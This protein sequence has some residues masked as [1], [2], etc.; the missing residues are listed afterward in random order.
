NAIHYSSG[1]QYDALYETE[2]SDAAIALLQWGFEADVRRLLP[3]LLEFVREAIKFNQVGHKL[4]DVA[5]YYWQTRDAK[6]LESIRPQW[7]REIDKILSSRGENGLLPREHYCN[8]IPT[9][10]FS[11]N[12]NGKSWRGLRDLSGALAD[13]G[14]AGEAK[15]LQKVA[16][17][18]RAAVFRA[19]EQ[20]VYT[21]TSPP[22]VP[23]ALFGEEQ[24]YDP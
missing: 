1:N 5:R 16:A 12:S 15:R 20:S 10:I 24:P 11:L 18:L 22:F 14:N 7:Q 13:M 21:N 8:D 4:E 19:V 17:D 3:P 9:P 6:F 2:G 23:V